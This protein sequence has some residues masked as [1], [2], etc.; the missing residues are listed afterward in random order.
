MDI[1]KGNVTNEVFEFMK[2]IKLLPLTYW[3]WLLIRIVIEW[4][5]LELIY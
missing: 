2:G 5:G 3:M 4:I 1:F